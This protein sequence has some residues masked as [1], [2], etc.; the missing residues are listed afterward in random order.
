MIIFKNTIFLA[1]IFKLLV[2]AYTNVKSGTV[3]LYCRRSGINAN[4]NRV[5]VH[6]QV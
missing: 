1:S 6:D 5:Q 2:G 3:H 4:I